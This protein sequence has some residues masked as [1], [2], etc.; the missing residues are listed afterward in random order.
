M[1][2]H[3][4]VASHRRNPFRPFLDAQGV[5]ILDGGLAT[6][7]ESRG[8][9]LNDPLWSARVLLDAPEEVAGVHRA[10]LEAGADCIA[11]VTYQATYEGF[12]TR[13]L[14]DVEADRVFRTAVSL[15]TGARDDFWDRP[16]SREGRL[17]PLVAASVGPYGAYLADGSEYTGRYDLDEDDL[18]AFHRR[19]WMLLARSDADLLACETIPSLPEARAL[20]GLL[21]ETPDRW[22]W[23]SFQCRDETHLADGSSVAEATR[24]CR[25][26]PRIA[27]VGFNCIPPSR[28]PALL[29][30]AAEEAGEVPLVVY[31]NSGEA[32]DPRTKAWQAGSEGWDP[33]TDAVVWRTLGARVIG[34][35]CRTGPD[36]I[37]RMR[38]SV[39][40]L[41]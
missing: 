23:L 20:L 6:T 31:P 7:L 32:Y 17:R 29:R 5:T 30:S 40:G 27:A 3:R 10:Y 4:G 16:S 38:D 39:L 26:A 11:T 18:T 2:P 25:D 24:L 12:A 1:E 9:D 8:Q 14:D 34:G 37:R 35:C 41:P 28:V 21:A 33:G 19:R 22:A 36:D 15:A 13:G